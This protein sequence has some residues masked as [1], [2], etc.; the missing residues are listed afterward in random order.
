LSAFDSQVVGYIIW[1][2]KSGFRSEVIL[3]LEQI[4]VL[5]EHHGKGIG[6]E[7]IEKSLLLVKAYL[8]E[9]G[10]TLNHIVVSTRADNHAQ[11][12]YKQVLGA[13]VE[14][15]ISNLY[16]ADEVFMVARNI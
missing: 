3:E 8:F 16:S 2:Q 4:A 5:P 12:L 7:L 11:K 14:A 1:A 9:Q 15:K 6:R 10:S 13:E